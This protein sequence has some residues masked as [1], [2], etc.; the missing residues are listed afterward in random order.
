MCISFIDFDFLFYL[1]RY[2]YIRKLQY[3]P[4]DIYLE[5]CINKRMQASVDNKVRSRYETFPAFLYCMQ[6]EGVV[7]TVFLNN[8]ITGYTAGYAVDL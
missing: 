2:R 1:I 7:I 8:I 3:M 4:A 6:F 5:K